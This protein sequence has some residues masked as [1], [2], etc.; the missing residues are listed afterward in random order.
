MDAGE[1]ELHVDALIRPFG[2]WSKKSEGLRRL[3]LAGVKPPAG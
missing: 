1:S 3:G 2:R